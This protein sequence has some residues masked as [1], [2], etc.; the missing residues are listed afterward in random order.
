[1]DKLRT[2]LI[3]FRVTDQEFEQLKIACQRQGAR[4][5][6]DFARTVML[7]SPQEGV[8]NVAKQLISL[9]RRIVQLENSLAHLLNALAGAEAEVKLVQA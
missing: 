7:S 2:R 8:E 9:D 6:S 5:M 4:C 3:N 1:M